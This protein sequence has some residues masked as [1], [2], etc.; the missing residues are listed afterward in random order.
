M[1]VLVLAA[2]AG[3]A[4]QRAV[5]AGYSLLLLP[6]ALLALDDARAVPCV[7]G[8]GVVLGGGLLLA[9]RRAPRLGR[10]DRALLLA[11]PAGQAAGLLLLG[12]LEGT[13]LRLTAGAVLVAG[14]A[15]ALRGGPV[16]LPMVPAAL[17]L[18]AIGALT[19]VIGPFAALLLAAG[20]PEGG[21]ELRRRLWLTVAWLS[22]TSLALAVLTGAGDLSGAPLGAALAP[23][24]A[25]GVLVGIPLARRLRPRDH[26]RAVL[27]VAAAGALAL[28]AS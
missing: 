23:A 3:A 8:A 9:G 18:G 16:R 14:C 13:A 10:D 20:T 26:R 5:G 25:L 12:G 15:A 19:G 11:A 27:A 6:A 28:L 21:D 2:V 22:A 1:A 7:L 17:G 4:L 24:L